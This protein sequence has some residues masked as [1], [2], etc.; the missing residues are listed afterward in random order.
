MELNEYD[1]SSYG[2]REK[3]K[4]LITGNDHPESYGKFLKHACVFMLL[5]DME[6][7]P[8]VLSILKADNKGYPWANQVALPGGHVDKTDRTPLDTAYRELN[9]EMGIV[10]ENVEFI[11]SMGFF[12]TINSTQIQV[13][14]GI[15]NGEDNIIFD[16]S[17][18]A[19]VLKIPVKDLLKTHIEK[20]LS[21]RVP[22]YEELLYPHNDVVVWGATARILHYFVESM[23]FEDSRVYT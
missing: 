14:T 6:D 21:G 11:G 13:F 12:Q 20:E 17:E 7:E 4:E 1:L 9:E 23:F 15:W 3:F 22:G 8:A 10:S 16:E 19:K 2:I 18:I 5:C